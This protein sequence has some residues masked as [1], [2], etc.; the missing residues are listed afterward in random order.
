MDRPIRVTIFNEF[1]HEK[2][3]RIAKVYPLSLIHI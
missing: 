3:E 1:L 2:T